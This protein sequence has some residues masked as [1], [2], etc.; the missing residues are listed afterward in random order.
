MFR[1]PGTRL[2]NDGTPLYFRFGYDQGVFG[3][4]ITNSDFL[5]IVNHPSE[6]LLGFIGTSH[7]GQYGAITSPLVTVVC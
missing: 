4:L 2:A 1:H 6:G 7:T 3:G 5:D